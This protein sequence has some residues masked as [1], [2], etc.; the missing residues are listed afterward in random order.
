MKLFII[1]IGIIAFLLIGFLISKV[2]VSELIFR[3]IFT[4]YD[5]KTQEKKRMRPSSYDAVRDKIIQYG[6][7]V[8]AKDHQDIYIT[9]FDNLKLHAMF[10]DNK[11]NITIVMCHGVHAVAL[12]NFGYQAYHLLND[13]YKVVLI[14]E[15]AHGD[16]MGKYISYGTYESKDLISWSK[17]LHEML[18]NDEIIF[19]GISMGATSVSLASANKDFYCQKMIIDCGFTS[20]QELFDHLL[21][22]NKYPSFIFVKGVKRRAK[23]RI[24]I[25]FDEFS[26]LDTLSKTNIPALFIHGALDNVVPIDSSKRNYMACSSKKDL[27]VVDDAY[28][29]TAVIYGGEE[30]LNKIKGFIN[31]RG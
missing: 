27:I 17:Y 4:K 20:I 10:F 23:K 15:R 24:G 21:D 25:V 13:G 26:T 9:S 14:D 18:P 11:K 8:L 29:T 19:Y 1:I 6:K 5:S 16:S 2:I 7:Q 28:H 22:A 31:E 30:V 12:D 3:T